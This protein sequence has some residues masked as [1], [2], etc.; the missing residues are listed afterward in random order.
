[1]TSTPPPGSQPPPSPREQPA[2]PPPTQRPVRGTTGTLDVL[3]LVVGA[4]AAVVVF[5]TSFLEWLSFEEGLSEVSE[6]GTDVPVQFLWDT[7]PGSTDPSLLV[8]LLPAAAL[9][10]LGAIIGQVR[11]LAVVGGVVAIV[12]A[13]VFVIQTGRLLDDLGVDLGAFD[14]IGIAPYVCFVAGAVGVVAG[15]LRRS[16]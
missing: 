3:P 2:P 13:V 5:V 8:V 4:I 6:K 10:L 1:M 14:A 12:V 7:I 15:L 9:I 16:D 11:L